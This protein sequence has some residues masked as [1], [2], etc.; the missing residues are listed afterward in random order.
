MS[1]LCR[2][3]FIMRSGIEET[4]SGIVRLRFYKDKYSPAT[5]LGGKVLWDGLVKD[6]L[7]VRLI[8]GGRTLHRGYTEYIVS[9]KR[10]GRS[11]VSFSSPGWSRLLAQNEPVPGMNYNMTLSTLL[12]ANVTIPHVTCESGTRQVNYIYVKEH[13]TIWDA[14]TA[15]S[16]KAY[17]TFPYIMGANTV[18]VTSQAGTPRAYGPPHVIE[19]GSKIDRRLMLSKAY[20]A[21]IDGQ[22][23]YSAVNAQASA[24]GM[25]RERYYPLDN[26]WLGNPSEGPAMKIDLSS[27]KYKIHYAKVLGF[28]GEELFDTLTASSGNARVTGSLG[29]FE[30]VFEK[31]RAV[32]TLY[33]ID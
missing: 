22:Y 1:E 26:Q 5:L 4:V 21:D 6:V 10:N 31:G 30:V 13:S 15:Y 3:K 8:A 27:R 17:G 20:M 29:G 11:E 12:Q 19:I 18:S 23:S 2:L 7:E 16:R 14:V 32:T 33:V 25:I 24:D 28:S 9:R